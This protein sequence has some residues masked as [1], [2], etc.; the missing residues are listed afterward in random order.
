MNAYFLL[1]L[2]LGVTVV[3]QATLNRSM[4]TAYGLS[5]VMAINAVVFFIFSVGFFLFAHYNPKL[6]PDFVQTRE[7]TAPFLWTYI[8]PGFCGFLLVLGLPWA[9]EYA[10]AS[11]SFLLLIASQIII[12]FAWEVIHSGESPSVLKVCGALLISAGAFLI[13][14]H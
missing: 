1:P 10:G 13:I 4:A 11:T 3:A 7:M 14:K 5:T 8:I 12:S 2:A 6:V 9:I